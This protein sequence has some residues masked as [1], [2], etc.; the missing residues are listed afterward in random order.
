MTRRTVAVTVDVEGDWGTASLRGVDEA[1]PAILDGFDALSVRAT[2]FVVGEVAR[3]RPA[4]L[5]DA[6][7][8]GHAVGSHSMTHAA[9]SRCTRAQ[10]RDEVTASKALLEDLTG[11]PCEAF[12]APFFDAPA[13]LGPLL[14]EA[15][16]RWSSSKAPFSPVAHYRHL[17]AVRRPHRLDD[18]RVIE[19]PVPGVFGLPIPEG[20]SYRRLFWPVTHLATRP[21]RVFY[22]HPHELLEHV[23]GFAMPGWTRPLMTARRGRKAAE[24]LWGCLRGWRDQGVT[25]APPDPATLT[26]LEARA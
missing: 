3:A 14:D 26:E 19:F 6:V 7:S 9:L 4:A 17:G 12:R 20:L 18:S 25:F 23:D 11:R 15:G 10:R 21:P 1:L 16:Y 8:R 5:R 13:D 2:L 24:L 22:L